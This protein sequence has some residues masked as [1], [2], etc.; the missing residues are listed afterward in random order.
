[1]NDQNSVPAQDLTTKFPSNPVMAQPAASASAA[2]LTADQHSLPLSILLHLLP[3]GVVTLGY[4]LLVPPALRW[5]INN[6]ITLN[7]LV[8]AV[9]VPIELGILYKAGINKNGRL[10][11]Q[12][13]VLNRERLTAWQ[14]IVLVVIMFLWMGLVQTFLTPFFDPLL[15]KVLFGWVPAWFPLDTNFTAMPRQSLILTLVISLVSTS[16]VAPVVEE[17]YFRGYLLPRLSRLGVWAPVLNGV[18]FTLYHFFTPWAFVERVVMVIPMA[19]LVQ[20]KKN[21]YISIICH[22]LVN[23]VGILPALIL[24]L[25]K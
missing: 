19:W 5:G 8:I 12:G 11:L 10:S 2:P 4:I 14:L 7:I 25:L 3:G 20:K 6:L 23:T 22:L 13:V 15:Q 16:W 24:T 18:L 21:L 17:L 9:L 1:M